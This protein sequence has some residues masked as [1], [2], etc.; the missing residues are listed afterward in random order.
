[1]FAFIKHWYTGRLVSREDWG[2]SKASGRLERKYS[3]VIRYHWSAKSAR[4][5]VG[6][7]GKHI[8]T[9]VVAIL[10]LLK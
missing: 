4:V 9:L 5:L 10:A 2:Y 3:T 7:C 6:F 8:N 1:M